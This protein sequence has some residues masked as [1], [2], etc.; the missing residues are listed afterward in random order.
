MNAL[1]QAALDR[2]RTVL[3]VL[4]LILTAGGI[5]YVSIP[6]EA[7]PDID[8]PI[9]FVSVTYSGISPEDSERLLVRPLERELMPVAGLKELQSRA[10]E[11]FALIRLDFEPGYDNRQALADVREQVDLVRGELPQGTDE[12]QVIEVDL[13]MFPV[14]TTTLSGPVP[15]RTLV[16]IARDLRDRLES[17]PGV[18]EVNIGGDRVDV[19]EVMVDPLVMETYRIPYQQLIQAIERNNR[20]VAAGAMDTG[21]GR[22]TLK[23]PGVIESLEDVLNLPVMV[24][25][26]TVVA[27]GDVATGRR[28]FK[29]PEGFA[30]IN[31]QPAVSLEIRKRGGANI[32]HTVNDAMAVIEA[33]RADW[34]EAVRVDHLQNMADDIADLLGDLENNVILAIVLVMLTIV[35]ALGGRSSWLVG[36]AIP[37]AFLGG[38]LAIH[39]MGFTLNIVVLFSLI[40]VVG[41]LV[42]GA[43]VVVEQADRYLAEGMDRREAFGRAAVRMSWPIIASTLTTLAVF[44]PMLFWPG[45]V[46]EFMFF[47]PATVLVTLTA[48]L[49][50]ALI[51]IPTLG[52]LVGARDASRPAQVARIQA[53]ER[54]D[55]DHIDGFTARYVRLLRYLVNH[56]GQ[57]FSVAAIL[58]VAAYAAY[59]QFGRGVDFFPHVE[60]RFAQVQIQARGDLSVWEADALVRRVE[61]RLLDVPEIQTVYARTIGTPRERLMADYAEDVIGVIQLELID[62]RLRPPAAEILARLRAETADLPGLVLQ[63]REQEGG[64][65]QGKPIQVEVSGRE[66]AQLS[67]AV[68]R[69]RAHMDRL[70]GFVDV[71]DDRSLPGVEV[72]VEVDHR[73]AARYG[74]D[75]GLLGNA[76][77]MVTQGIRLGGY[78]PE[79]ADEEVDI[80]VR[81]PFDERNLAQ[82]VNLRVPT[83]YGLVPISN[84]VEFRPAPKTGIIKRV[85]G[86]RSFTVTADAA[87]GLLVDDQVRRLQAALAAEPLPEGVE[88][89][90]RGQAEEQAEAMVFL[91]LAFGLAVFLM[92]LILVTQFNSLYQAGLV[93]SAIVFSTAGVLLGLILRQEAFGIVMSGVGVIA[94]AGIVVNNN[95]VLIDTYN[96]LRRQGLDAVEAAL[97]TGAQRLRPVLLTTITTILGLT[98]MVFGLTVD[99]TGRDFSIGAPSTQ[100]WVQLATAISGGL[101]VATPLTLLVTPA[102]LVWGDRRG[103][104]HGPAQ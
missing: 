23:V 22:V 13:S 99:F 5:S 87:A 83:A 9:F 77:Q 35:A 62:W 24:D 34:P 19:L 46:G 80:R 102:M 81:F 54:G 68:T 85:D 101:L 3:L 2:N 79:D 42:D 36:L 56:P 103:R 39:L 64:P 96:V 27:F 11:G 41:M 78:R 59:G 104:D 74:A 98:P 29:D 70:G 75:I 49:L 45:M 92:F 69:I 72:R 20:L 44:F 100:Y 82:L 55:Y 50:M 88:I 71:E 1:I 89:R 40:L 4:L 58:V 8:I 51:F 52:S 18:L 84:F 61:A 63:F 53:A 33:A 93:L 47:L 65:Q 28:T 97:R 30:R 95:I 26:G 60:P 38:I 15:E 16:R 67:E 32:I 66:V 94:L 14:L 6:K 73:E 12:P 76:V 86:R 57:T 91:E 37:G 31:G 7:A 90:F 48:S 10:G 21:A 43:I 17:L 25:A